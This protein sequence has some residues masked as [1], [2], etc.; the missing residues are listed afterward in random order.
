MT[1]MTLTLTESINAPVHTVFEYCRDPS[2]I[3]AADPTYRVADAMLNR[4]GVGTTARLIAKMLVFTESVAI[5]YVEFVPDRRIVFEARPTMTIAGRRLGSEVFTWTW[6]FES[7]D[8]GTTLTVGGVNRGG[9]RWERALDSLF[10]TQRIVSKQ[11]RDRLARIKAEVEEQ[12]T[13]VR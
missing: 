8:G 4:G 13:A 11:F 7:A 5:E 6:T 3:Y 2:R 1:D 10:G 12:A 9:S